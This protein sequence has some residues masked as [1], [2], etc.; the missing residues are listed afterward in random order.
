MQ[1]PKK[2]N[3]FTLVELLVALS[4]SSIVL[5]A[6]ATLGYAFGRGYESMSDS[7]G[8]QARVR[9]ASM[10]IS[11]LIKHSRLVCYADS[12]G[13]VLW[14]A[15]KNGDGK[16][17]IGELECLDRGE[18]GTSVRTCSF[19]SGGDAEVKLNAIGSVSMGWWMAYGASAN[20][21]VL[22]A[23][24]RGVQFGYDALAPESRFVS[25]SFELMDNGGYGQYE[26][27]ACL[28]GSASNLLTDG[29][30]VIASDDD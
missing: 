17:N 19:S 3:G 20:Y 5:A 11:E 10:R 2:T 13:L 18:D 7:S 26:V 27:S 22:A 8:V 16:I 15:D 4:V 14:R 9:Y 12:D 24:C 21:T 23:N 28:R 29:T 30:G 25:V 6:V 1:S